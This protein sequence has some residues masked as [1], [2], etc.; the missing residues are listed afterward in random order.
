MMWLHSSLAETKY[1]FQL[2][3]YYVIINHT[4]E[5]C[6]NPVHIVLE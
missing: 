4:L 6:Y 2:G 5:T 3:F 1:I